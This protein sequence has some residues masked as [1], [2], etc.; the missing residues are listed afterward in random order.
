MS[1]M[2]PPINPPTPP[3]P[4]APSPA[5]PLPWEAPEAGLKTIFPTIGEFVRRP[6]AAYGRMSLNV[7]LVRP[8]AYFVALILVKVIVEVAWQLPQHGKLVETYRTTLEQMG[9]G[10]MW[11]QIGPFLNRPGLLYTGIV[12]ASPLIYL[13]LLFVWAGLV[14]VS[15]SILGAS[16]A[17]FTGTLR[18]ISYA[19]T[20]GIAS[21]VPFIGGL[22]GLIWFLILTMVGLAVVHRA[23]GWKAALATL[24]PLLICCVCCVGA[25]AF[26]FFVVGQSLPR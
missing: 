22:V 8:L 23:E 20:S 19:A 14:H 1:E 7:D 15:G 4:S 21:I 9:Q 13:I 2:L 18:V 12:V 25:I 26:S 11:E 6:L 5:A 24:A 17:G 16:G 3:P 10:A